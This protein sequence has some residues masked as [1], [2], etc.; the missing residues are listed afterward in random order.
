MVRHSNAC[1]TGQY[2]GRRRKGP[3]GGAHVTDRRSNLRVASG[4]YVSGYSPQCCGAGGVFRHGLAL[5]TVVVVVPPVTPAVV[6]ARANCRGAILHCVCVL[7]HNKCVL[8]VVQGGPGLELLN[9]CHILR[10]TILAK[11]SGRCLG[12]KCASSQM[13]CLSR[14]VPV[15]PLALWLTLRSALGATVRVGFG[16]RCVGPT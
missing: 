16:C 8:R 2:R 12:L 7:L 5:R 15:A 6:R 14:V 3:R 9:F 4:A 11:E 13:G 10:L 1:K